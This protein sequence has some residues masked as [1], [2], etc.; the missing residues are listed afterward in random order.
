[1][2]RQGVGALAD[3]R[4]ASSML[5][6]LLFLGVI[7][8]AL[9][10]FGNSSSGGGLK[11]FGN[12][13]DSSCGS[14]IV[15][16]LA[17][18]GRFGAS[19]DSAFSCPIAFGALADSPLAPVGPGYSGAVAEEVPLASF[20]TLAVSM[21]LGRSVKALIFFPFGVAEMVKVAAFLFFPCFH[22]G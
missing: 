4:T 14:S 5:A 20:G 12:P 22:E 10:S 13:T 6:I 16:S 18:A 1:L 21:Y 8:G 2:Q 19:T 7:A 9:D 15:F 11:I 3:S 17:S